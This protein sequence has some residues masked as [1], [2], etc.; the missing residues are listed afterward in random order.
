[1]TFMKQPLHYTY[2]LI[3]AVVLFPLLYSG[4]DNS[5]DPRFAEDDFSTVPELADT[6]SA[7]KV[8]LEDGLHY[9]VIKEGSGPAMVESRDGISM[10]VTLR[11]SNGTVLSST[12]AN[13]RTTP[14]S[15]SVWNYTSAE[16]FRRGVIGMKA[17]EHRVIVIPPELGFTD[18][19]NPDV[20]DDTI[21]YEVE[22]V[23][24]LNFG[25]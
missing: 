11:Q 15:E 17:G 10:F 3:A 1:M 19:S 4:C 12:Y 5:T 7:E 22:L 21:T 23:D 13:G 18:T 8:E 6:S 24:I 9:Y 14:Q 16:G 20:R 2:L 25:N